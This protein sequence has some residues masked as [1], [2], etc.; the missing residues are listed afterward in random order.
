M[1]IDLGFLG[2]GVDS[3]DVMGPQNLLSCGSS[4]VLLAQDKRRMEARG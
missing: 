3:T 2:L 1:D 4:S